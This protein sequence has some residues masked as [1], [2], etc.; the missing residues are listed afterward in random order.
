MPLDQAFYYVDIVFLSLFLVEICAKLFGLGQKYLLDLINAADFV[1][2]FASITITVVL[3][4]NSSIDDSSSSSAVYALLPLFKVV[5]LLRVVLV[6]T[7][8]QRSRERYRRMKMVGLAAPVEKVFEIIS[9]L[10]RKVTHQ[11]DDKALAWTM[12]LIAK[13]ELYKVNFSDSKHSSG[14]HTSCSARRCSLASTASSNLSRSGRRRAQGRA[15]DGSPR[16][17]CAERPR[18]EDEHALLAWMPE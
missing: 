2:I 6:M 4:S 9:D 3:L 17:L 18:T 7:R 10:R 15:L 12:D 16:S 13:E 14:M 8:I 11:E 1:I 5:R